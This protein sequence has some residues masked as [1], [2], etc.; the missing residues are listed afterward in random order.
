[1]TQDQ[2]VPGGAVNPT[3]STNPHGASGNEPAPQYAELHAHTNFSLLDGTSDP[4]AMVVQA[5]SLG[6]KA[7]AITD[8]DSISGIVRFASEAKRRNVHAIIGVELTVQAPRPAGPPPGA[9]Q[10]AKGRRSPAGEDDKAADRHVVLLAENL[11]GYQNICRLLTRSYERGGKDHPHV[12]FDVL[13]QHSAGLIALSACPNGELASGLWEGGHEAALG[14]AARYRDVFGSERYFVE[15]GRHHLQSDGPRNAGLTEVARALGLRCVATNDAHYHDASRALLNHV[16]TCI[17]HG[18]TLQDAGPLLRGNDEY[19]LKSPA[20][21]ARLFRQE[22]QQAAAEGCPEFDPVRTAAEIADRCSFGL[23]DI[24]YQF[25]H[26][27]IPGGETEYSFLCR[28][29]DAGKQLFYPDATP[30]I[31]ARLQHELDIVQQLDLAGYL[32]V[33]REIVDWSHEH[34]ILCSIRGIAE[35]PTKIGNRAARDLGATVPL[36]PAATPSSTRR[37]R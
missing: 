37:P 24:Q 9:G 31:E 33:F 35:I 26:P 30:E 22:I 4:E 23:G 11:S 32:L 25:P 14:V 19:L 3:A 5:A 36:A 2:P 29:V 28:V 10:P 13:A 7:L 20:Q 16:V 15:L 18:T 27:R 21:M 34:G 8:H 1:M 17:R 12:P 6:L